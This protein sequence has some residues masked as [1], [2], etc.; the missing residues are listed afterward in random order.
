[1]L[2]FQLGIET[3]K[4]LMCLREMIESTQRVMGISFGAE[5]YTASLG[6]RR[7]KTGEELQFARSLILNMAS[8]YGLEATNAVWSNYKDT[9]GFEKELQMIYAIGFKSKACIHPSQVDI[10]HRVFRPS[11]NEVESAKQIMAAVKAASIEAGGVIALNGKMV[12]LPVIKRA[13]KVLALAGERVVI[14]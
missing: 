13:E 10:V 4:G 9:E 6:I 7:S 1:M 14:R 11:S 2:K 12:D 8:A 5:D 3:P